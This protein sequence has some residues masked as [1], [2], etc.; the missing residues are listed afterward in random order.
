MFED[1]ESLRKTIKDVRSSLEDATQGYNYPNQHSLE[2]S[3]ERAVDE[4]KEAEKPFW[5]RKNKTNE[6]CNHKLDP[7]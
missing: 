4:L 2:S 1:L 3:I 6:R 5:E 7:K